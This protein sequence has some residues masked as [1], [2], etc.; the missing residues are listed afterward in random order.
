M[1]KRPDRP[2]NPKQA[3]AGDTPATRGRA[4]LAQVAQ[5]AGVGIAT[6]YLSNKGHYVPEPDWTTLAR[7]GMFGLG[8]SALLA[9]LAAL[10]T[11]RFSRGMARRISGPRKIG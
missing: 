10:V 8:A 1:G 9:S 4:R 11:V 2:G 6:V 3:S 5:V 7:C